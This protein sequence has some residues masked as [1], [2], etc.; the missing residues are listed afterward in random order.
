MGVVYRAVQDGLQRTVAIKML[1]AGN[2]ASAG[3]LAR[4]R[5]EAEAVAR[6]AH[7]NIVQIFEIGEAAGH[8]FLAFEYIC[9][10]NLV[11][12]SGGRP[13]TA[14]PLGGAGRH[15]GPRDASRARRK[16]SSIAI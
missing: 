7:P 6:L 16:A 1:V 4:F 9:R 10:R 8:P 15:A 12:S 5:T 14:T 3:L 11:G 13:T 2:L